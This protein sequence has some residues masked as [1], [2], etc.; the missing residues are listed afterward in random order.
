MKMTFEKI[1]AMIDGMITS[2]SLSAGP[3]KVVN[4]D[5]FAEVFAAQLT[6]EV[7]V[8]HS[9]GLVSLSPQAKM[10]FGARIVELIHTQSR[11]HPHN[12]RGLIFVA[13]HGHGDE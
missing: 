2:L 4:G 8:F 6:V 7:E 5:I 11:K 1:V 3:E 10:S 12:V 9:G 13:G